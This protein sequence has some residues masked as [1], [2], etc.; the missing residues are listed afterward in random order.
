M[1]P[2]LEYMLLQLSHTKSQCGP[3]GSGTSKGGPRSAMVMRRSGRPGTGNG[4]VGE[5]MSACGLCVMTA[6]QTYEAK[7]PMPRVTS[8]GMPSSSAM[9]LAHTMNPSW[10]SRSGLGSTAASASANASPSAA[11]AE[12]KSTRC[13]VDGSSSVHCGASPEGNGSSTTAAP[14]SPARMK[15]ALRGVV[16]KVTAEARRRPRRRRARWSSGMAWPLAMKGSMAT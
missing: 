7:P 10:T 15:G 14:A 16:K 11:I 9:S 5:L 6:P 4:S 12:T 8:R 2:L 13:V 1:M 3:A